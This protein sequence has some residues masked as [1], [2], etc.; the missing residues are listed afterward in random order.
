MLP[1]THIILGFLFA[2]AMF[3]VFHIPLIS[4]SLIFFSS[5]LI[6]FD[7]YIYGAYK[8]KTLSFKK[9]YSFF[10]EHRTKWRSL[11]YEQKKKSKYPILLFHGVEFI[12]LIFLLSF[13]FNIFYFIFLGSLFHIFV[14]Y[15]EVLSEKDP[16]YVKASV[17]YVYFNNKNK[18]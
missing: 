10:I 11:S 8:K 16:L 9:I 14:D 5:F 15:I 2:A 4:A 1:K 18:K 12:L 3:F 17:L 7:H 13:K 6:D